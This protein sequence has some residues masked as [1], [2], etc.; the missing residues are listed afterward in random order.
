MA[1]GR[2]LSM[3][4][5]PSWALNDSP[6]DDDQTTA[7]Q[8]FDSGLDFEEMD[9]FNP[10]GLG[11]GGHTRT[12]SFAGPKSPIRTPA[13]PSFKG[14]LRQGS[15]YALSPVSAAF[16]EHILHNTHD[17]TQGRGH[18]HSQSTHSIQ[19][20]YSTH[21]HHSHTASHDHAHDHS[22]TY[23]HGHSHNH[24]NG[25]AHSHNHGHEHDHD[26]DRDHAHAHSHAP[27]GATPSGSS[28]S[29]AEVLT[30]ILIPLPYLLASAAYST[31]NTDFPPLSAYAR[32]K[33]AV[34]EGKNI[35][36]YHNAHHASSL[37]QACTLTSGT[38]LLIAILANIRASERGLDKRKGS[39]ASLAQSGP[40]TAQSILAM[41]T[42]TLRVALPYFAAIQI[43]GLRVGL[44]LLVALGSSLSCSDKH[45]K[46]LFASASA[47]PLTLTALGLCIL[48]DAFGLTIYADAYH[49]ATGYIALLLSV[50]V[51]H[52]PLPA[53][54]S[55]TSPL[56][57]TSS[58]TA[59]TLYAGAILSLLTIGAS[60]IFSIAPSVTPLSITFSTLS[61]AITAALV[62]F[63]RP[64]NLRTNKKTGLALGCLLTAAS[65]FLFSPTTWPGT[66]C[67]GALAALSYVGVLYDTSH[68]HA[69]SHDHSHTHDTGHSHAH[70]SAHAHC[71]HHHGHQHHTHAET[72]LFTS[73]LLARCRPGSL[74]HSILCERDSRRIAYF[75]CLNFGF[76]L[77]QA[78]YGWVS[79]S[80]GLLSDTVHMFFDCLALVIGLGAAVASKW[81]TSPEMPFGWGK[82]NVL[83]GF[84]NGIFLMLVSV[85]FIWEAC[86]GI[87]E[88]TELRHVEELL[89]VSTLGFLVNMVGLFA[90]G[91][92]HHGHDHDH[93]H[94]HGNEN[95]HG[96]YLHVA[97]DAG[98]SL[99]V[100]L[101]T[102][103]TLWKPWY[104]WD[105]LA[106]IVIAILIFLAAVPLVRD[107]GNKLLLVIP[108]E[109]EYTLKNALQEL[110][111]LRGVVGYAVPRFW[112]EDD[113]G[114]AHSHDHDHHSHDHHEHDHDHSHEEPQKKKILGVIHVF[115]AR[116]ADT[117]D[118]RERVVNYFSQLNMSVVVQVEREGEGRCWCGGGV[119]SG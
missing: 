98:G 101:S 32:L 63:A 77:V 116:A 90:F 111:G 53:N 93:D 84:G 86:E 33:Q 118:V 56:I 2:P 57:A 99:A 21:S 48:G 114:D 9:Q 37:L 28:L 46:S 52:P 47:R 14:H 8:A 107:S 79:G 23:D 12:Y 29:L 6:F 24:S 117:E 115:A 31:P 40:L 17:S 80:L 50:F 19:S 25:N 108:D 27:L 74:F 112:V 42:S 69:H 20:M 38:L 66:F 5:G 44:V 113:A 82:L 119:K 105:P 73:F 110:S 41:L 103:L 102:I 88:G 22:H 58:A 95:M 89:V 91:H 26:H 100:I 76:M 104:L 16:P 45:P 64:A 59:A 36:D 75:T 49:L 11:Q 70:A 34:P 65:S 62:L 96:I 85:E 4:D 60:I 3:V 83:A 109:L 68:S 94:G 7:A 92:A 67:N 30:G 97:A 81:P 78:F 39:N 15:G 35:E 72:S 10:N 106:T 1:N 13:K 43:G 87:M 51:L 71:N 18:S 55:S 54:G 61:M